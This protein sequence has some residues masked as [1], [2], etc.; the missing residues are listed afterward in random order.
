[1]FQLFRKGN[2]LKEDR[3]RLKGRAR[4]DS[5]SFMF[6]RIEEKT[7]FIP[8]GEIH[9]SQQQSITQASKNT[10]KKYS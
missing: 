1:M 9:L 5:V 6:Y 4:H 3:G 10:I 8:P 7:L 2:A